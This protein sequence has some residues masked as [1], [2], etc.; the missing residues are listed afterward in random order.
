MNLFVT[1]DL[2]VSQYL[3]KKKNIEL[4]VIKLIYLNFQFLLLVLF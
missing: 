3:F 2:S 1:L 4:F